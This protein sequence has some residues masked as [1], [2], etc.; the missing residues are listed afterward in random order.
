MNIHQKLIEVRKTIKGFNKDTKGFN[1]SYVSGNQILRAIKNKMDELGILLIPEV[2]YDS[3][4]WHK[5]EYT[6]VKGQDKLDFIIQGKMIYKWINADNPAEDYINVPWLMVGQQSD[7]I[8]KAV[9]T[10]LTYNERYFLL[11]FFNCPTDEDDPDNKQGEDYQAKSS[12]SANSQSS[13]K[14]KSD[15]VISEPQVKRLYAI[16]RGKDTNAIKSILNNF[17]YSAATEIQ[18]KDYNDICKKV[19]EL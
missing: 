12:K 14:S 7:D 5:H 10:A 18:V 2:D 3:L 8:S 19:E 4:S 17:G 16:G 13:F 1:Y 11:K 15:K 9:G 6:N